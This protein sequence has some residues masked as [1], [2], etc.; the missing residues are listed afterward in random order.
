MNF[1]KN[2]QDR[3]AGFQMAPMIDVVFLLLIFFMV[4]S[5]FAEW[6]TKVGI[7]VPTSQTGDQSTRQPDEIMINV[8]SEGR[9][10]IN[11]IKMSP[12][13]IEGLLQTIGKE[14]KNPPVI[15][16]A[17]RKTQHEKIIELLDICRKVDIWNVSFSTLPNENQP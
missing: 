15:I 5:I 14:H 1:R 16:R 9:Y 17:D 4:A 2:F 7:E 13:R 8:D 6:E 11:S 3:E 12:L 10:F